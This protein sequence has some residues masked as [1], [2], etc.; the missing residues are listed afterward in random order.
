M[1]EFLDVVNAAS[2]KAANKTLDG[3]TMTEKIKSTM[4]I[5]DAF[6]NACMPRNDDS[7]RFGKLIKIF[8]D[9]RSHIATG[10]DITPYLL[11]KNRCC[12]QQSWERNFHCF[13]YMLS[14]HKTGDKS[15]FDGSGLYLKTKAEYLMLNQLMHSSSATQTDDA[16]YEG[17]GSNATVVQF[18]ICD[19]ETF[20]SRDQI[21]VKDGEDHEVECFE[22][23]KQAF[24]DNSFSKE[25]QDELWK[26]MSALLL[27]GNTKFEEA[28]SGFSV[29]NP[30]V[31]QQA[32]E[33]L[34][35]DAAA[36]EKSMT[37]KQLIVMGKPKDTKDSKPD[38]GKA[39]L[40]RT[41]Y[42]DVF[43]ELIE[44]FSSR[45]R[46]ASFKKDVT[47]GVLDIFGFEFY[48]KA[49]L[50]A[51]KKDGAKVVN[52]FE[53]FCINLTNEKLQQHFVECVFTTEI[54][55]Y[56]EQGLNV[57][58]HPMAESLVKPACSAHSY[59]VGYR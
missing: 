39:A 35:V 5:M 32:A 23:L 4:P 46:P 7:S 52:S 41:I 55:Q 26:I 2:L 34:Q 51:S 8:Y 3:K 47:L 15:I 9:R 14:A 37:T 16:W 43:V 48:D 18:V 1:L 59:L 6:G 49:D 45:L 11:E 44:Q 29:G 22:E 30:E 28:R 25:T 53:Q 20:E 33:L 54:A 21:L 42:N 17:R 36:L 56:R 27:M 10:A 31:I 38:Q 40:I 57:T 58:P 24:E 13:Y 19:K 50:V 12:A